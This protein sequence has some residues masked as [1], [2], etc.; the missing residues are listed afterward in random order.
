MP[1]AAL[2]HTCRLANYAEWFREDSVIADLP[3]VERS[4]SWFHPA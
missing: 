3:L 2:H 4:S 1:D